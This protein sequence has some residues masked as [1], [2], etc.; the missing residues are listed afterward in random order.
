[1]KLATLEH[2]RKV[3]KFLNIKAVE[4]E[5]EIP[6]LLAKLKKPGLENL[7]AKQATKLTAVLVAIGDVPET[8]VEINFSAQKQA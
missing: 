5:C 2:L 3:R 8:D 1:M 7:S 6:N 4:T